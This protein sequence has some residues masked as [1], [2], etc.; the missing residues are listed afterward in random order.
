MTSTAAPRALQIAP[1]TG[2][3]ALTPEQ[4][5]FN[6]LIGQIGTA[7]ETL[8]V[9]QREIPLYH[10]AHMKRLEPLLVQLRA[11]RRASVLALDALLNEPGWSRADQASLSETL[12]DRAA[13]LIGGDDAALDAEMRAL[14][15]KHADIDFDTAQRDASLAMKDAMEAMT[16]L[17]LGDDDGIGSAHDVAERLRVRHEAEAAAAADRRATKKKSAAQ[18]RND[19]EARE[20]TQSVRQ[21]FRQL[22]SALHPDREL[23]AT[24]RDAKT[25]MMQRANQ[26]YAAND[27]L[28]LLELQL[29]I[30]LVDTSHLAGASVERLG[31]Y[32]K[33]LAEQL[34][35]L[36]RELASAQLRFEQDFGLDLG[37][38]VD[39]RK[40]G[41][42]VDQGFRELSAVLAH[43]RAEL[44]ALGD[45]RRAKPWLRELRRTARRVADDD[46]T[47]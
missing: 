8:A 42:V 30:E 5:R 7:R 39:P 16:G 35:E 6:R 34:A 18:R 44:A 29:E 11:L 2:S 33:V 37:R 4:K 14:F 1:S 36:K 22:A 3:A 32:N 23:D 10:Q 38:A 13:A 41:V 25:A 45:R 31:H 19:D 17:D 40:L 21:V 9:W 26:A 15:A 12:C 27:L 46:F 24:L 20:A 43:Q 47:G 28:A